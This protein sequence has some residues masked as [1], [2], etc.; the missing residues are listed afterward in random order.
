[1]THAIN[2]APITMGTVE[3]IEEISG[4]SGPEISTDAVLFCLYRLGE[5]VRD[6]TEKGRRVDVQWFGAFTRSADGRIIFDDTE[7]PM[8]GAAL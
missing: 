8:W 1:M 6:E 5:F 3:L 2:D 4:A 7:N